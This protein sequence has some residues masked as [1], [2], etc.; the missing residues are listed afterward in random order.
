MP[1]LFLLV[2]IAYK[3]IEAYRTKRV[4]KNRCGD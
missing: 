1:I 2:K 3:K 4:G